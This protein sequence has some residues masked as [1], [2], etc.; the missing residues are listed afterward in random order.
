[1]SLRQVKNNYTTDTDTYE[2][3]QTHQCYSR[4]VRVFGTRDENRSATNPSPAHSTKTSEDHK[5]S[6]HTQTRRGAPAYLLACPFPK[7]MH[8]GKPP[9]SETMRNHL[10]NHLCIITVNCYEY[11]SLLDKTQG[12]ELSL[13]SWPS[14]FDS[15]AGSANLEKL[16]HRS[17]QEIIITITLHVD[18]LAT[19]RS[20]AEQAEREI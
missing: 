15:W 18:L 11:Q 9:T 16:L 7:D 14:I 1:M 4:D 2:Y 3:I 6:T 20:L 19:K 13:A 12:P 5:N 8:V 10:L 17:C